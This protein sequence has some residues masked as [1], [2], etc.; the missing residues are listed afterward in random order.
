MFFSVVDEPMV[1]FHV[2]E[3]KNIVHVHRNL[4]Y[5]TS[6][7]FRAAFTSDFI[8]SA[9]QSMTLP[10]ESIEVFARFVQWLY[11]GHSGISK[12]IDPASR[13]MQLAVLSVLADKYGVVQL[14]N[15]II[16]QLFDMKSANE[17][18]PL[19]ALEYAYKNTTA[20]SP[21]R[22]IFVDWYAWRV[23]LEWYSKDYV[24]ETF[25]GIPDLS[26]D[27]VIQ[28]ARRLRRDGKSLMQG[29]SSELHLVTMSNPRS[30]CQDDASKPTA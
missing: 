25:N 12:A 18:P 20:G 6:Q 4:I 8:E 15:H 29:P 27:L 7:M 23:D 21:L 28:F 2:G 10:E 30:T 16:D 17:A 5:S 13:F 24:A 14:Q 9:D 3:A 19:D 1:T 11:Q 22:K 26:T